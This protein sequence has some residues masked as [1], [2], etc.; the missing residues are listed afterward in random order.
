MADGTIEQKVDDDDQFEF[1]KDC[2]E[3]TD[4]DINAGP[5]TVALPKKP[6]YVDKRASQNWHTWAC[7]QVDHDLYLDQVIDLLDAH[8]WALCLGARKAC[9]VTGKAI[10]KQLTKESEYWLGQLSGRP[11]VKAWASKKTNKQWYK[12][13]SMYPPGARKRDP[14][15]SWTDSYTSRMASKLSEL[16]AKI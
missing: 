11:T 10:A 1:I 5:N 9:K 3:E 14:P 2:F 8:V 13:F 15:P 6:A 7:H 4:W 16:F 12:P